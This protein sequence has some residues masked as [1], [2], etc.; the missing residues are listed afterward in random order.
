VN[1]S[2]PRP[3]RVAFAAAG[4]FIAAF[5]LYGLSALAADRTQS[6]PVAYFDRLAD[7]FLHGRLYLEDPP[8]QGDLTLY[9]DHWYLPHPPLPALLMLPGVALLGVEG[10]NTV[11]FANTL[12][13]LNVT[14]VFLLLHALASAGWTPLRL[15]DN[16]WLTVLFG[17]GSVHWYMATLG[18]VWFVSQICTVTFVALAAWLV[19]TG[20][21]P[22]AAGCA[23][24]AAMLARPHVAFLF[25][26]LVALAAQRVR[27]EHGAVAWRRLARWCAAAAVP[28]IIAAAALLAYNGARF[29]N[30]LDFGYQ[31]ENVSAHVA[32]DLHTY[33]QFNLYFLPRNLRAMLWALP[34]WGPKRNQPVPDGDGLSLFITTPALLYLFRPRRLTWP[35]IGA[36]IATGL[37]LVP[38]LT[39]FNTGWAQ[40]GYRFS[41]DFM[42]PIMV[43]L[44]Y[45]AGPRVSPRLRILILLGVLVNAWGV[46][47]FKNPHF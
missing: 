32:D 46:S 42:I 40:F 9:N 16:L 30:P 31:N 15:T 39:Y 6:P 18:T 14:L 22:V 34:V 1:S 29:D 41:L 27:D 5:V 23:L 36:A 2:T 13:A 11:L 8:A 21:S 43:V 37:V 35:E 33:G 10:F 38:L 25:P 45:A 20:R 4:V 7:A 47:W 26:L 12:G 44:A 24:G 17:A 19:V 3:S 28:P